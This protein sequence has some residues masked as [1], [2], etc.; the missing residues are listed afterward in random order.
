[1]C[2]WIVTLGLGMAL[3]GQWLQFHT[4]TL[5]AGVWLQFVRQLSTSRVGPCRPVALAAP[6][7][8]ALMSPLLSL[9]STSQGVS[10]P[11][12]AWSFAL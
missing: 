5:R 11:W 4:C 7:A 8:L 6:P 3:A 10:S 9:V 1:M 2:Y 12:R